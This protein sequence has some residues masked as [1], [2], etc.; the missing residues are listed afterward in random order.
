MRVSG[1]GS[2]KGWRRVEPWKRKARELEGVI[3]IGI[4]SSIPKVNCPATWWACMQW[5]VA[6]SIV[7]A[8]GT[9]LYTSFSE[10]V[11]NCSWRCSSHRWM[12]V[13]V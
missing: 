3:L 2:R 4:Y 11:D 10:L 12:E 7:G 8:V 9:S 13:D 1:D 6:F 5:H